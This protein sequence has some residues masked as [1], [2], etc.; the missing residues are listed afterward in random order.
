MVSPNRIL[1][2][3]CSFAAGP[4]VWR[5]MLCWGI[6]IGALYYGETRR[7]IE[8]EFMPELRQKNKALIEK[9]YVLSSVAG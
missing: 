1:Q 4:F 2:T 8:V 5:K 9:M 6:P 7:R 3:S